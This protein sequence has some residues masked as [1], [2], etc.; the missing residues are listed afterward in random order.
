M[1]LTLIIHT[2][3]KFSDLWDSHIKLLNQ[4]W[5]DRNIRTIMVTDVPTER[6]FENVEVLCAGEG[7]EMSERV[8]FVMQFVTTK[9][10]LVTLDDYFPIYKIETEKIE[11][12]VN[13]METDDISYLRLFH[14]PKSKIK[15]KDHK[16]LKV[17]NT[18]FTYFVNLYAGI[19][20]SDLMRATVKEPLNAWEYEVSLSSIVHPLNVKC[21]MSYGKE[22]QILDVVRK[23]FILRKAYKYLKKHDLY[24]GP[25]PKMGLKFHWK[26]KL[27]HLLKRIFPRK[28]VIYVKRKRSNKNRHYYNTKN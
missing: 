6:T 19:W 16:T 17:I 4:N 13:L 22:F 10:I 1:D 3:Q 7:K 25:R 24:D 20:K 15:Y 28:F 5:P 23:G 11:N 18:Y 9:Y 27:N 8:G 12:L 2:C 21:L 26:L 14:R